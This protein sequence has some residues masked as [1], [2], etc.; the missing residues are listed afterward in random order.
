M[1][2]TNDNVTYRTWTIPERPS[3]GHATR[4]PWHRYTTGDTHTYPGPH[5]PPKPISPIGRAYICANHRRHSADENIKYSRTPETCNANL[6]VL[7][8]FIPILTQICTSLVGYLCRIPIAL[9]EAHCLP[10]LLHK[11]SGQPSL[12][13]IIPDLMSGRVMLE[14]GESDGIAAHFINGVVW[15]CGG[16]DW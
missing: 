6:F 2:V 11:V 8:Q 15:G 5:C 7:C 1:I 12:G 10:H 9:Q 14:Q 3:K 13:N 16:H 4:T